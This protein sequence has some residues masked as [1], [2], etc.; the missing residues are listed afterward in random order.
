MSKVKDDALE[1]VY[2]LSCMAGMAEQYQS[3]LEDLKHQLERVT[4]QRDHYK[5]QLKKAEE[6]YSIGW[7]TY[8]ED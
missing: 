4:F 5:T 2:R 8:L 7:F 6:H 1:E 3:D